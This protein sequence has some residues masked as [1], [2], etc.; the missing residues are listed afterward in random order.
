MAK[1][2]PITPEDIERYRANYIVEKDGI[3]LYRAMAAA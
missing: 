3:A 2:K 1:T